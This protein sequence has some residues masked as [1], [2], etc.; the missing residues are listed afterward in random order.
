MSEFRDSLDRKLAVFG[1]LCIC[2]AFLFFSHAGVLNL[3]IQF[4]LRENGALEVLTPACLLLASLLLFAAAKM[5]K[6]RLGRRIYLLGGLAMAFA[7]GEELSWGQH[8]LGFATPDFLIGLNAQQEFNFHNIEIVETRVHYVLAT[9][10]LLLST[11]TCVAFFCRKEDVLGVPL[12]SPP[13]ALGFLLIIYSE[14][15]LIDTRLW[16]T[17][18]APGILLLSFFLFLLFSKQVRLCVFTAA[19]LT[20]PAAALYASFRC[21]CYAWHTNDEEFECLFALVCLLYAAELWRAKGGGGSAA[22][23]RPLRRLAAGLKAPVRRLP[24]PWLMV[25]ALMAAGS[26]G[27]AVS[28]HLVSR[29][30]ADLFYENWRETMAVEPIA[31]SEFDIRLIGSSLIYSKEPCTRKDTWPPFF[32]HVYLAD[33]NGLPRHRIAHGFDNLDF[34]FVARKGVMLDGKCMVKRRLRLPNDR[35]GARIITGQYMPLENRKLW[36]AEF[37]LGQ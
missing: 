15:T 27:L 18:S 26:S 29:M 20:M 12:P 24:P 37:P 36:Q 31:R 30:D 9:A 23:W 35:A 10:P 11:L 19:L 6:A 5:E 33:R 25:S 22:S 17:F 34:N 8:V 32:L 3:D 21:N 16:S 1:C 13:L 28:G 14:Y 7:C 4:L 2:L